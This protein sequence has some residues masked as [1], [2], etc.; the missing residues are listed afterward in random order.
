M[1]DTVGSSGRPMA[2]GGC[3]GCIEAMTPSSAKRGMSACGGHL[4]MLDAVAA[5]ARAVR[6]ARRLVAVEHRAHRAVAD[7]MHGDLQAAPV[8][9]DGDARRTA[10]A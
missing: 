2:P 9:L 10:P 7:R 4:D 6:L 1:R 5:V 3:G 8:G